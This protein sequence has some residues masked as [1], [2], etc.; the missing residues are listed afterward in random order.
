MNTFYSNVVVGAE[1]DRIENIEPFDEYEEFHLKC[2]HYMML[3][4]YKGDRQ[5][6]LLD[7]FKGH[8]GT[9]LIWLLLG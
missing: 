6:R 3:C 5:P 7:H 8:A 9:V 1:Q 4:A 2:S